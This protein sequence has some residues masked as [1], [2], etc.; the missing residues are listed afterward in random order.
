MPFQQFV[1][2]SGLPRTGSTLL[3][4]I[5]SQNPLIH[6]EGNSAVS[7]LMWEMCKAVTLYKEQFQANNKE[8][9]VPQF[10]AN[11][12]HFYYK[13]I[14]EPIVVDKCRSWTIEPNLNLARSCID[15]NIK[16][17]VM[18]RP[19]NDIIESFKKLYMRNGITGDKLKKDLDKLLEPESDPIM[20]SLRGV[21][22]A[23][24]QYDSRT[25]LFIEYDDLVSNPHE[26]MDRIYKFCGWKPFK[27]DF[28]NVVSKW[29][30]ND[31]AYGLVGYH[32]IRKKVGKI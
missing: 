2:L 17:I 22:W 28:D 20:R 14:K 6:A 13:D 1:C 19:L 15:P 3:S 7:P 31:E 23:K 21:E 10:I 11:I 29:P 18:T 16:V 25:F 9:L 8:Y 4:A 24:E 5:L 26:T 12:P 30:E 32:E 27:H